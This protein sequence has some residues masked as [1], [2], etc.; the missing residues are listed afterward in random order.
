MADSV[1][2][3]GRLVTFGDEMDA[4]AG[5]FGGIESRRQPTPAEEILRRSGW[6]R[7]NQVTLRRFHDTIE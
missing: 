4:A 6:R 2:P 5:G 3:D 7:R 1:D